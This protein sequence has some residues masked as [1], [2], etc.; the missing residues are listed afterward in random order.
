MQHPSRVLPVVAPPRPSSSRFAGLVQ[1]VRY[2]ARLLRRQPRHALLT[3]LT[4][5]LGIGATT[6]LFSVAYGVLM[7]PLP[8]PTRIGWSS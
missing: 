3:I 2:A 5:A 1:D 6:V 7:K 4:M 8:W